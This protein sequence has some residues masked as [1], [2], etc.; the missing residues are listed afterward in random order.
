MHEKA[1][2]VAVH[3]EGYFE[4]YTFGLD[5]FHTLMHSSDFM[6]IKVAKQSMCEINTRYRREKYAYSLLLDRVR[7]HDP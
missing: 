2:V 3:A 5:D 7:T 4:L 1:H 6:H